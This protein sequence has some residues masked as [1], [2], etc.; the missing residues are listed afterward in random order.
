MIESGNRN[1]SQLCGLLD[2][3][4]KDRAL[5][6]LTHFVELS[7]DGCDKPRIDVVLVVS[8]A[9]QKGGERRRKFALV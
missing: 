8:E 9:F 1:R 7:N 6:P 4:G 5:P 3:I 2:R